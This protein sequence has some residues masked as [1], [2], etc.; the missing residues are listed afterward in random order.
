MNF[1]KWIELWRN[2][3]IGSIETIVLLSC[4]KLPDGGKPTWLF[5]RS[6]KWELL[7]TAY[8]QL[9][10]LHT[11]WSN[12]N[13]TDE[14]KW[15]K[16]AKRK[17]YFQTLVATCSGGVVSG[18]QQVDL[19]SAGHW[20]DLVVCLC[21]LFSLFVWVVEIILVVDEMARPGCLCFFVCCF[22]CLF[23]WLFGCLFFGCDPVDDGWGWNKIMAQLSFVAKVWTGLL[24]TIMMVASCLGGCNCVGGGSR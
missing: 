10:S 9:T 5:S 21:L 12:N 6:R 17:I 23:G 11:I 14:Q 18:N 7:H 20:P 3:F 19:A 24:G 2:D 4:F 13:Q 16:E 15:Q 1:Q 22:R 8:R